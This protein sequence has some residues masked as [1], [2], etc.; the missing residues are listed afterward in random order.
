MG[1]VEFLD[2]ADLMPD[3]DRD[4][5]EM[6][7]YNRGQSA[8][9]DRDCS[10]ASSGTGTERQDRAGTAASGV[11]RKLG[12]LSYAWGTEHVRQFEPHVIDALSAGV[13]VRIAHG[14]KTIG[15]TKNARIDGDTLRVDFETSEPVPSGR[16]LSL[17][18]MLSEVRADGEQVI[19]AVTEVALVERGRCG[20]TCRV[21][22][23]DFQNPDAARAAMIAANR[24]LA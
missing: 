6:I 17:G 11:V 9:Q 12:P 20:S 22:V 19:G 21:D 15:R 5:A 4:R 24:G 23:N 10:C 14:G 18:Y 13:P 8:R 1:T 16:E 3:P 2:R 7:A